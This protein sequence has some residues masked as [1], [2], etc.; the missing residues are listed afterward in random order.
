MD[1]PQFEYAKHQTFGVGRVLFSENGRINIT[2]P[3]FGEK[4]ILADY[5]VPASIEE[6]Q[7]A[8]AELALE[9]ERANNTAAI[10]KCWDVAHRE[11]AKRTA[12]ALRKE[13]RA[14]HPE[15]RFVTWL[16]ADTTEARERLLAHI[17]EFGEV[18]VEC[19]LDGYGAFSEEYVSH[20][21]A[22]TPDLGEA[23]VMCITNPKR[24][25]NEYR[26]TFPIPSFDLPD[27]GFSYQTTFSGGPGRLTINSKELFFFLVDKGMRLEAK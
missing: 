17:M 18:R 11:N 10:V 7:Q 20:S 16:V 13:E 24:W 4:T 15:R 9:I 26:A 27:L 14:K 19:T 2:F 12:A 6:S 8:M 3:S 5:L 21:G 22:V 23:P 25:G 1:F